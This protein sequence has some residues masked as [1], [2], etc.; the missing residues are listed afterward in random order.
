MV[1][2][3]VG[4]VAVPDAGGASQHHGLASGRRHSVHVTWCAAQRQLR[5]GRVYP[6]RH[7]TTQHLLLHM[8]QHRQLRAR[9][10]TALLNYNNITKLLTSERQYWVKITQTTWPV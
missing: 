5:I 9:E 7:L 3:A 10:V 2:T 1:L 8:R 6:Q 4:Q